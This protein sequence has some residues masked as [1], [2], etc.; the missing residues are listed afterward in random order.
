MTFGL[1]LGGGIDLQ[2]N[3]HYILGLLG[4]MHWPFKIAQDHQADLKGTYFKLLITGM[5]LF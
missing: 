2:L 1:N 5:Y 3:D 4:Q